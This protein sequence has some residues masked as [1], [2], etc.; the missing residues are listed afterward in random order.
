MTVPQGV[1]RLVVPTIVPPGARAVIRPIVEE[2]GIT[3]IEGPVAGSQVAFEP[4]EGDVLVHSVPDVFGRNLE[5][6]PGWNVLRVVDSALGL[7]VETGS[8]HYGRS[9]TAPTTELSDRLRQLWKPLCQQRNVRP[10][11]SDA[12]PFGLPFVAPSGVDVPSDM[13]ATPVQWPGLPD[14]VVVHHLS[15]S[16]W[17]AY[18]GDI[19]SS[20]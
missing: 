2:R 18:D 15:V 9:P 13:R 19:E 17:T 16:A 7:G 1:R 6:S 14:L 5:P 11:L 3:I 20:E 12:S 8:I 4:A 10:V